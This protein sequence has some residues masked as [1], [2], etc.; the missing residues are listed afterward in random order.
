MCT[1]LPLVSGAKSIARS[2]QE[3]GQESPFPCPV[4]ARDGYADDSRYARVGGDD[5]ER[6]VRHGGSITY[7]GF[8]SIA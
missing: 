8:S 2:I 3:K 4:S 7:V 5:T 6:Y 1:R